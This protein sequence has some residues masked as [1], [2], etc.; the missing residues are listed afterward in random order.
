MQN[1]RGNKKF[2]LVL[3]AVLILIVVYLLYSVW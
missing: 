1:L 3:I 2:R